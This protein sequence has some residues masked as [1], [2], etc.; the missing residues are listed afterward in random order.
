MYKEYVLHEFILWKFFGTTKN[1]M[2]WEIM[3]WEIMLWE[4]M[5]GEVFLYVYT[6]DY[7]SCTTMKRNTKVAK[8]KKKPFQ[9]KPK[10]RIEIETLKCNI[11]SEQPVEYLLQHW[12]EVFAFFQ[13]RKLSVTYFW[14]R[15]ETFKVQ[16]NDN[17]KWSDARLLIISK[18]FFSGHTRQT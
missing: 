7:K 13:S 1:I 10:I 5:L 17:G 9:K 14:P 15:V 18:I 8:K 3:L 11:E 12:W 2:L 6:F 16:R 4:I